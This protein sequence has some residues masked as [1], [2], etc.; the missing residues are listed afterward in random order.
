MRRTPI[1]LAA[2]A[3]MALTVP[4]PST[5]QAADPPK[6]ADTKRAEEFASQAFELYEKGDFAGAVALYQKAYAAAP[7]GAILFNIANIYDKKLRDK[8]NAVEYYRRYLASTDTEAELV[9]RAND[10][11]SALKLEIEAAKAPTPKQPEPTSTT[12][13]KTN[14]GPATTPPSAEQSTS[15]AIN[16]NQ[17]SGMRAAGIVVG[18]VGIVLLG[19]GTAFGFVAKSKNDDSNAQCS[20]SACTARGLELTDSARSAATV[21]TITFVVGGAAVAGGILLYVLAPRGSSSTSASRTRDRLRVTPVF[22]AAGA[23]L[24]V[25]GG[26]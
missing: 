26:F 21:S 15:V 20:G 17:G 8:E 10:R 7:A 11:M 18:S 19:V 24:S 12:T 2:C 5:A 13:P 16:S 6:S 1:T 14:D 23:G 25:G 3:L 9:R 4:L 22:S